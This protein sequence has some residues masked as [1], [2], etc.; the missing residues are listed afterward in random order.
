MAAQ[1][2]GLDSRQLI[3]MAF[4]DLADKAENIG[5]LNITPDLLTTLLSTNGEEPPYFDP[6]QNEPSDDNNRGKKRR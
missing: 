2:G 4:R 1:S 5:N 6:A 3:A